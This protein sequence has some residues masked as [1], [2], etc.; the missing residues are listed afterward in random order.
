[1]VIAL[2]FSQHGLFGAKSDPDQLWRL[3]RPLHPGLFVD[4]FH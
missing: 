4:V 3:I 2:A 1:V